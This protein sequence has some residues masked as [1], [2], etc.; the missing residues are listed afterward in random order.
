[1]DTRSHTLHTKQTKSRQRISQ[2]RGLFDLLVNLVTKGLRGHTPSEG[3][4]GLQS[5]RHHKQELEHVYTKSWALT[6][7]DLHTDTSGPVTGWWMLPGSSCNVCSF[8]WQCEWPV[9]ITLIMRYFPLT[10]LS[11]WTEMNIL[12]SE[13]NLISSDYLM[14][15]LILSGFSSV[16][17]VVTT[18]TERARVLSFVWSSHWSG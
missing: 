6:M 11:R 3:H 18:C 13:V 10:S 7:K 2:K 12:Y 8:D 5:N 9:V 17:R 14:A 15:F 4:P 16:R 1:M